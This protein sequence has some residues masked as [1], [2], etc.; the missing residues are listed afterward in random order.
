V[1]GANPLAEAFPTARQGSSVSAFD[2]KRLTSIMIDGDQITEKA[3]REIDFD[4]C[5]CEKKVS[6]G[7]MPSLTC[8]WRS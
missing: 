3:H 2:A 7:Y 5:D 8:A 6:L 4:S 1:T